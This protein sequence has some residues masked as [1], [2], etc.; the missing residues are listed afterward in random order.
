M[1]TCLDQ[2]NKEKRQVI[3]KRAESYV[4][5]Y[6]DQEREKVRLAREAKQSGSYYVPAEPKV[7]FVVRIK[8][9]VYSNPFEVAHTDIAF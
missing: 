7:V 3:F 6:R 4:K 5:E 9:Y 8:G 1:L 2:A